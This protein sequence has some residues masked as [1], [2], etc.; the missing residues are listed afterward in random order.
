MVD[1][2]SRPGNK[3]AASKGVVPAA[4]LTGGEGKVGWCADECLSLQ[5]QDGAPIHLH[6]LKN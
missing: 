4:V 1:R 5:L 2:V 3:T 6:V